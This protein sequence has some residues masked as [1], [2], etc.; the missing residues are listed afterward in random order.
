MATEP[1]R[2]HEA[3]IGTGHGYWTALIDRLEELSPWLVVVAY[4]VVHIGA[5]AGAA[6][7]ALYLAEMLSG[8]AGVA[9]MFTGGVGLIAAAPAVVRALFERILD[10]T[11]G[12]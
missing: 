1:E 7:A 11:E 9:V 5:L 8:A 3:T 12:R 2:M 6:L 4:A 10:V